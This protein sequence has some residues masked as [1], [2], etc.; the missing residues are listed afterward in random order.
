MSCILILIVGRLVVV[1]I[2]F[3]LGKVVEIFEG[4]Y[5]GGP[6]RSFW[7]FLL[8]YVALRYLQGK[9]GLSALQDVRFSGVSLIFIDTFN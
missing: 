8:A 5:T 9:G 1:A 6:K 3:T 7:P 4:Y 2:P